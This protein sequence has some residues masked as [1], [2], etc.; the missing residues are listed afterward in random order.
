MT[1]F[2][3]F[4]SLTPGSTQEED[5]AAAKA[6]QKRRT[7]DGRRRRDKMQRGKLIQLKF[8]FRKFF[9]PTFHSSAAFCTAGNRTS[10]AEEGDPAKNWAWDESFT[11]RS[12]A[13]KSASSRPRDVDVKR[14]ELICRSASSVLTIWNR[15]KLPVEGSEL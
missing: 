1:A 4:D 3:D 9:R 6:R 15:L 8:V 7:P 5:A 11:A 14:R 2:A 12:E 13:I 10:T